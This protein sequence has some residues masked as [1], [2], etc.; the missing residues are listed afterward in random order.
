MRAIVVRA[1]KGPEALELATRPDPVPSANEVLLRVHATA[2]NRA[3][4]LQRRGL[5]PPPAGASE[6]L[7]LEAAGTVLALG[8]GVSA[9]SVGERVMC[10]L[11]GGGYAELAVAHERTLIPIPE[12]LNF[13]QAAA[14]P[15]AFLTAQEALFTEGG[16]RAGE[17]ALIHAA[18]S[19]VGSA[20]IQLATL[21]GARVIAT[22]GSDEKL[23][24]ARKLGAELAVARSENF[25]EVLRAQGDEVDVIL[26]LVGASYWP[27]HAEIL[28]E[29]GR[30]VVVGLLGGTKVELDLSLVLRRRL[31]L[32]GLVMRT[33]ALDDKIAI[34]QRFIRLWLSHLEK[35]RIAPTIDSTFPLERAGEAHARMEQNLNLGKIVLSVG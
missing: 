18:A 30:L 20:A 23:A 3:D 28:R 25:A 22:A 13:E 6:I 34:A 35:G 9:V 8:P 1:G 16:L 19:G 7:G 24:L 27:R 21:V 4:L 10:I 31:Q 12:R 5:Y 26:D 2:L 29:G 14:I 33:R 15:E 11:P 32:R 17:T